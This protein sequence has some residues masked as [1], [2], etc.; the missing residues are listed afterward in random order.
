MKKK[1]NQVVWSCTVFAVSMATITFSG[2]GLTEDGS[3]IELES[4]MQSEQISVETETVANTEVTMEVLE[5]TEETEGVENST[6]EDKMAELNL[7]NIVLYKDI[8]NDPLAYNQSYKESLNYSS[9]IEEIDALNGLEGYSWSLCDMNKDGILEL[10][11]CEDVVPTS[12]GGTFIYTIS[13]GIVIEI[14]RGGMSGYR[15]L[16][17][18]SVIT[19]FYHM[20]EHMTILSVKPDGTCQETK[21]FDADI[22]GIDENDND[23]VHYSIDGE[24]VDQITFEAKLAEQENQAISENEFKVWGEE[25]AK[26]F[27]AIPDTELAETAG[28]YITFLN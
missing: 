6:Y 14:G 2:C 28:E 16:A 24:A 21:R 11:I 23:V 3:N 20:G 5:T 19:Y 10:I 17:D 7:S 12:C 27:T 9:G 26:A 15:I 18:G 4:E 25:D 8:L 13:D 1:N 22:M